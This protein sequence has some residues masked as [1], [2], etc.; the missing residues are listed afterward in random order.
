[1][2]G[3]PSAR[4]EQAATR[5]GARAGR[6][7]ETTGVPSPNPFPAAR[8]PTLAAAWRRGYFAAIAAARATTPAP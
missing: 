3:D 1:V 7:F 5:L 2:T 4:A 8:L 6:R